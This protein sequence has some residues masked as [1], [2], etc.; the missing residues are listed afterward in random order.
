MSVNLVGNFPT[1]NPK[2]LQYD[3]GHFV[4]A[5]C[6]RPAMETALKNAAVA[7]LRP[8]VRYLIAHGWGYPALAEL[9]KTIYVDE[10]ERGV[11]PGAAPTDSRISLLTGVHRKDVKRLRAL[12]RERPDA[13]LRRDAGLAT[14]VVAAWVSTRRYLDANRDPRVLPLRAAPG[15]SSFESLVRE[16][17]ADVRP[18]VVLDE[19]VA[20]GVV[21]VE[22]RRVK[23]LRTAYVSDLPGDKLDFLA[24]NIGDHMRAAFRNVRQPALPPFF[25]RAVYYD[26]VPAMALDKE[27]A[28]M[29]T[30][31]DHLLRSVNARVMRLDEEGRESPG[32]PLRRMRLGVY[33][34]EE[35]VHPPVRRGDE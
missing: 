9:L 6:I 12:L 35:E 19:L 34:Y 22:G 29:F 23:L 2:V 10:A 14:R 7:L 18:K 17:R 26:A 30:E 4:R 13:V 32:I 15:R 27:R 8:L 25:E 20:A 33:Y 21:A 3:Y 11:A 1:V 24:A 31:S 5:H 16:S 28:R